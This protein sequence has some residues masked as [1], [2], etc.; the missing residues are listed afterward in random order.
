MLST[1]CSMFPQVIISL[2]GGV[3]A[4]RYNRKT[5]I[6]LTDGFIALSTFGLAIAFW[7]GFRSLELLLAVSVVRSLGAG[8]QTPCVNAIFPQ[9][10]PMEKLTRI[11]G[12]NHTLG[13]VLLL[14]SPAVG[15]ALL[16]SVNIAW[17]FM[18]DVVTVILAILLF[19]PLADVIS[20][21]LILV[22]TGV[23]LLLTGIIFYLSSRKFIFH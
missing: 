11:Q 18:L 16:G 20:V 10:V 3:W 4:D 6:M 2:W 23:L 9:L 15:G 1:I 14:L 12:I 19:G 21:E 13:S 5:L 17:A 22:F 7:A 8:I